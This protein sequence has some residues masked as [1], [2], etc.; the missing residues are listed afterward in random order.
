MVSALQRLFDLDHDLDLALYTLPSILLF[1]LRSKLVA[2]RCARLTCPHAIDDLL[3]FVTQRRRISLR[4]LVVPTL[5]FRFC[6]PSPISF[7]PQ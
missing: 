4:A 1:L 5:L 2:C 7:S 6:P 3:P